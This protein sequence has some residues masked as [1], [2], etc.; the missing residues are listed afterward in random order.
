MMN[1]GYAFEKKNP[2]S[3]IYNFLLF[4]LDKLEYLKSVIYIQY[5]K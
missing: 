5:N 1:A 2:F 4:L 3:C